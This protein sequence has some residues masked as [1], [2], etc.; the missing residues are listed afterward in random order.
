[1]QDSWVDETRP[2]WLEGTD[3]QIY[4]EWGR[5]R[6]QGCCWAHYEAVDSLCSHRGSN[7]QEKGRWSLHE[8][9]WFMHWEAFAGRNSC[10]TMWS[11]CNIQDTCGEGFQSWFLLANNNERCTRPSP[12][13]WGMPIFGQTATPASATAANY[14]IHLALR[15]LGTRHNRPFKKAKGGYTHVMVAIDKF[16]KWIEYRPIATLTSPK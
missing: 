11:T 8:M 13:M 5:T 3:H 1:M 14:S 6:W 15:M 16:T 9:H 12:K 2:K 7:V 4:Q 10:R